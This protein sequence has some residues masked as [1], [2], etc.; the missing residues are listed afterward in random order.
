MFR[1]PLITF[2]ALAALSA[3]S[4]PSMAGTGLNDSDTLQKG[5]N[6]QLEEIV[7]TGTRNRTDI[8]HLPLTVSVVNRE[9]IE[10]SHSAS[11]LP[12][13]T[14][15]VPGFFSTSRGIMGYG[16]SDGSAGN[17]SIR[18]LSGG[19]ARV[20]VLI[21]GHPQ[22][23]GMFGHPISDACQPLMAEQVEVLRGPASVLYGSNAM[24]GVVNIVTRRMD[25]DGVKTDI[26][27]GY[28]SW[29]TVR[30]EITN[31]IRYKGFTS[32]ISGSYNRTDGHRPNMG[33][34]QYGG[35]A[36]LGYG[37]SENWRM[38][39]DLNITHFNA[40]NPGT[41]YNP[42]EDADQSITRGMTSFALENEYGKT[43]GAVSFFYN[44]GRH[45]IN[46]GY[47]PL[48]STGNTPLDY[49]FN[50]YDDM[51][52]IS[53]YQSVSLFKG[54][55]LTAGFDWYRF[56]GEAWNQYVSG[57]RNGEREDIIDMV[58]HEIAGYVDFRQNIG[59]WLTLDAGLRVDR[60][61]HVGTEWIPQAGMSFH[62]TPSADL[63]ISAHKGFRYPII[64]EMFMWGSANPDLQPERMW[65]Y[66]LAFSQ[67]LLQGRLSYGINVFYIDGDNFIM[68]EISDGRPHN[69]NAGTIKNAGLE[70]QAAWKISK[71]WSV[72]ANYSF[73]HMK[74]PVIAAPEHK[75]YA[76]GTFTHGR[77]HVSTG[78]MYIAGLYTQTGGDP[79]KEDFVLWNLNCSFRILDWMHVW[80]KGE[81]LLNWKYEINSGFPMPGANATGGLSFSF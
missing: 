72:N 9:E 60:H 41:V 75:L 27:A 34:E 42:L 52:G 4:V 2:A 51:M 80:I 37:I 21:D 47:H 22:Y 10:S 71:D 76:E 39:G 24:G 36:K 58:Q 28:G 64:R 79:V 18:G 35:Y 49:R 57:E 29:N 1:L 33:F 55:R 45:H 69:V 5:W 31:R 53:V 26:N 63:K 68:T 70:L 3:I 14:E 46:D 65:N 8:R 56:G 43:S 81:N 48:D 50:S 13:L 73:L 62:I 17:I 74:F 25:D 32:I 7:V 78:I 77:W 67:K 23:M 59:K 19:S 12:L 44:W 40:S 20:M 6:E 66:E 61:S 38:R 16:V 54:N 15:Q 11:L 30:T